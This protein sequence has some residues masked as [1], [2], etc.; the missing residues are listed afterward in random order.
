MSTVPLCSAV[1]PPLATFHHLSLPPRPLEV[2]FWDCLDCLSYHRLLGQLLTCVPEHKSSCITV[3]NLQIVVSCTSIQGKHTHTHT[4]THQHTHTSIPPT[5]IHTHKCHT[6]IPSWLE[7]E[8]LDCLSN[9]PYLEG[10]FSCSIQWG[11]SQPEFCMTLAMLQ[12]H[13]AL[14]NFQS[15]HSLVCS[16]SQ[17]NGVLLREEGYGMA[18]PAC[19]PSSACFSKCA[20]VCVHAWACGGVG[21]CVCEIVCVSVC[22]W[23]ECVHVCGVSVCMCV[24]WVH[25]CVRLYMCVH[26]RAWWYRVCVCVRLY[27]C[28]HV[29]VVVVWVYVCIFVCN[30]HHFLNLPILCM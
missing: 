14:G 11:T 13:N 19:T 6:K 9:K 7:T 29:C 1:L 3:Q 5:H 2:I 12:K 8:Q 28:V 21:A 23:C 30:T 4:P 18:S 24:V 25:V 15:G 10:F 26:A 27:M 20:R 22:V 17:V 16:P